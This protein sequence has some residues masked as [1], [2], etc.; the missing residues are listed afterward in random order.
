MMF[1]SIITSLVIGLVGII[2][3][4]RLLGKMCTDNKV[5]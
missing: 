3:I 4:T 2:V 1:V 5:V